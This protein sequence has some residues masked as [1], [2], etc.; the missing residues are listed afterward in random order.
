MRKIKRVFNIF[1]I[2]F[3]KLQKMSD[4]GEKHKKMCSLRVSCSS[5]Q[6][7]STPWADFFLQ[8]LSLWRSW[9]GW[10][11]AWYKMIFAE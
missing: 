8:K 9:A 6:A 10:K 1:H 2:K 4:L 3:F 7:A 5:S 11:T